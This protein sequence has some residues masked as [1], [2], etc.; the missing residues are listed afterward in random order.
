MENEIVPE[1]TLFVCFTLQ[2]L[3]SFFFLLSLFVFGVILGWLY[4]VISLCLGLKMPG[5]TFH[6]VT[7]NSVFDRE[8]YVLWIRV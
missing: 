3:S 1:L 7:T 8:G 5:R 2:L 6:A 4:C